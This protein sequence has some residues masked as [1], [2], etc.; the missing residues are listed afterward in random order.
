MAW[1]ATVDRRAG[2]RAQPGRLYRSVGNP[3]G[4]S[5]PTKARTVTS[6]TTPFPH[7]KPGT[8][9]GIKARPRQLKS[10]YW[11]RGGVKKVV[12]VAVWAATWPDANDRLLKQ[13]PGRLTFASV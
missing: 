8:H 4:R 13:F 10:L 6:A 9:P 11:K 1:N 5:E 3:T 12:A 7:D 2:L